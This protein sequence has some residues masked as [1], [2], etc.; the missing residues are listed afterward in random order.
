MMNESYW[1][2]LKD[3]HDQP[4]GKKDFPSLSEILK[5]SDHCK[6][7]NRADQKI[8][9]SQMKINELNQLEIEA[10]NAI[11]KEKKESKKDRVKVKFQDLVDAKND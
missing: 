8:T 5:A 3:S 11:K 6:K 2:R 10:R 1:Q 9:R 7:T 4:S